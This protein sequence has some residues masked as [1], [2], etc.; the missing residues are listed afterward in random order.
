MNSNSLNTVNLSNV[1]IQF[2]LN[3]Q[4]NLH[5]T[6]ETPRLH[7]RSVQA[8][9]LDSY[10]A[11]YADRDVMGKFADGSTKS[12]EDIQKRIENSWVKRWQTNDP[13]SGLAITTK[14]TREFVGH[15]ILGHGDVPGESEV[16][17]LTRKKFWN[18]GYGSEAMTALIRHYAPRTFQQGYLVEGKPLQL[19]RATS[20]PDNVAS[21]KILKKIGFVHRETEEK[22]GAIRHHYT[23]AMDAL[24][25]NSKKEQKQANSSMKLRSGKIVAF[26]QELAHDHYYRSRAKA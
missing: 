4:M 9:D 3:D 26:R 20:R 21:R 6:I 19:I 11:L 2:D 7:I 8:A 24:I 14:A 22:Y 13:Y 18:Q 16:A 15:I 25:G 17:I 5:V 23:L 1:Q 12:R 10:A